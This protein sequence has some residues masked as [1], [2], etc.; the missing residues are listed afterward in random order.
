MYAINYSRKEQEALLLKSYTCEAIDS[1]DSFAIVQWAI[2]NLNHQKYIVKGLA[3][4]L[5]SD[6]R[7]IEIY[8]TTQYKLDSIGIRAIGIVKKILLIF[9]L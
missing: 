4:S 6:R 2:S 9:F 8:G 7:T 3:L 5:L 1:I